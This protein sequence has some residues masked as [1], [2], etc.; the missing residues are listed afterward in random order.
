MGWLRVLLSSSRLPAAAR[1]SAATTA[2]P[3]ATAPARAAAAA[4]GAGAA[5]AAAG[6]YSVFFFFALSLALLPACCCPASG[7]ELQLGLQA[8]SPATAA[9]GTAAAAAAAAAATDPASAAAGASLLAAGGHT[10]RRLSV[11]AALINF[12]TQVATNQEIRQLMGQWTSMMGEVFRGPDTRESSLPFYWKLPQCVLTVDFAAVADVSLSD[13]AK[14]HLY[15]T[16]THN[17]IVLEYVEEAAEW[18]QVL[19]RPFPRLQFLYLPAE[20][21]ID[22]EAYFSAF[23]LK[24]SGRCMMLRL[25]IHLKRITR[26]MMVPIQPVAAAAFLQQLMQQQDFLYSDAAAVLEAPTT[27]GRLLFDPLRCIMHARVSAKSP[28]FIF[29]YFNPQDHSLRVDAQASDESWFRRKV[30]LPLGCGGAAAA[31]FDAAVYVHP[32]GLYKVVVQAIVARGTDQNRKEVEKGE[33]KEKERKSIIFIKKGEDKRP[34]TELRFG[35]HDPKDLY[36]DDAYIP[37]ET[38]LVGHP[39]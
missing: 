18:I 11:S 23:C 38:M 33:E 9:T 27:P 3:A 25:D 19:K 12:A 30:I 39:F 16:S 2:A 6:R 35:E 31:D 37:L 7:P 29:I 34:T 15:Y 4:A 20:C 36:P 14:V 8:S 13:A 21:M 32:E 28:Q 22:E 5:A 26:Q 1:A 24:P 17:A 10:P